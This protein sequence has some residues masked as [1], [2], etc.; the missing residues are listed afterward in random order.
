MPLSSNVAPSTNRM[1]RLAVRPSPDKSVSRHLAFRKISV[2][3]NTVIK[4]ACITNGPFKPEQQSGANRPGRI[5]Q[6][7]TFLNEA[8]YAILSRSGAI[9]SSL[10]SSLSP[11]S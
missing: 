9:P 5:R 4:L 8:G 2:S 7:G 3:E 11:T 6:H 1:P 10:W